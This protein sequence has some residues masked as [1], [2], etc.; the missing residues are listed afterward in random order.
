MT[1]RAY[2]F[3]TAAWNAYRS[4]G[5]TKGIALIDRTR[6]RIGVDAPDTEDIGV[7][8]AGP[9]AWAGAGTAGAFG[10]LPQLFRK[11]S[12]PGFAH[13]PSGQEEQRTVIAIVY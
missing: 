8:R 5:T 6:G 10:G 7:E 3:K 2:R 9:A 12:S 1:R 4:I 11:G 13:P